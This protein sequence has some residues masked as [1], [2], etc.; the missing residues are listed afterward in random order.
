MSVRKQRLIKL[1]S[2]IQATIA[3]DQP[4]LAATLTADGVSISGTYTLIPT[5]DEFIGRGPLAN[6]LVDIEF[7]TAFPRAEPLVREVGNTIPHDAEHHINPDGTCCVVIWEAW[8]SSTSNVSIQIYFDGP[9]RNFFLGQ[10][11]KAQTGK[12]PF[13][14][15]RHGKDGLIDAFADRLSCSRNEKKV[16]YL[17]R[18]LSKD[19]P[20][21]HWECPCESGQIIRKCCAKRLAKLSVNVPKPDAKRM[22]ARLN[23]Y[24]R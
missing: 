20:K 18:L 23:A 7:Q 1:L 2:E 15:E 8:A 12:W 16:R 24:D 19:W 10:F 14:E 4:L 6:Y 17:L 9:L 11:Q 13:G 21:G 3:F 5:A 22:L